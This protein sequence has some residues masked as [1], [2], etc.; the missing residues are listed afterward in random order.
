[1]KA[2]DKIAKASWILLEGVKDQAVNS[3]IQAVQ[4][5]HVKVEKDQ[6]ERLVQLV[7][8][9]IE[10]GYHKAFRTFEKTVIKAVDEEVVT[11]QPTDAKKN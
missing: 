6:L 2:K 4:T 8:T 10:A 1:M 3:L 9:S 5:G 11:S 7:S